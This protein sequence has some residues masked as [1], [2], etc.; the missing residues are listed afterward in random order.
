MGSK[1]IYWR[2]IRGILS[3]LTL[4][5][6]SDATQIDITP[7]S[8][9]T[10]AQQ[11]W[12][13]SIGAV[14][15]QIDASGRLIT[16]SGSWSLNSSF[17]GVMWSGGQYGWSSSGSVSGTSGIDT[18]FARDAAGVIAARFGTTPHDYRIYNTY[19]N[20]SNYER[21]NV[22]FVSNV[23]T[24]GSYAAGT[25]TLRGV[26]LGVTGNSV[27]VYGATPI[28][29]PTTGHSAATF[30][31]NSGTAVNDAST[32][33]GYTLKQVVKALRDFGVLT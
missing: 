11:I 3:S 33:D 13:T 14:V 12:R 15:T 6:V 10:A 1:I 23:F 9:Q 17:N 21:G 2:Q 4:T 28:A 16:G 32:F 5:G 27:G 19:T 18:G 22:G 29:R 7:Y 26:S 8:G 20:A 30:V 25:G 31:A 24:I